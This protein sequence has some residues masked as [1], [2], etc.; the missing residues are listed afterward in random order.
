MRGTSL[1]ALSVVLLAG[2]AVLGGMAEREKIYGKEA[3]IIKESFASKQ[4]P[5]GEN[6]R[7]YL[8]ASDVV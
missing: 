7:V 5:M 3:P 1:T 4:V 2:C 8:N 6:W